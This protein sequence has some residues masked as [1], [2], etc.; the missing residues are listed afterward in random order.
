M[1]NLRTEPED[2]NFVINHEVLKRDA[3][4]LYD[5][6]IRILKRAVERYIVQTS[7]LEATLASGEIGPGKINTYKSISFLCLVPRITLNLPSPFRF[8]AAWTS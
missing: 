5:F 2:R 4:Q 7:V 1:N 3:K 8:N 6:L